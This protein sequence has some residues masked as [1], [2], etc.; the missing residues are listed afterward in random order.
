MSYTKADQLLSDP[1]D[2]YHEAWARLFNADSDDEQASTKRHKQEQPS[3]TPG[4][5]AS[6]AEPAEPIEPDLWR[7]YISHLHKSDPWWSVDEGIID[8]RCK[9]MERGNSEGIQYRGCVKRLRWVLHT[10]ES[11]FKVGMATNLGKRWELYQQGDFEDGKWCPSHIFILHDVPN[12]IAA[13]YIEAALILLC[14]FSK[15]PIINNLNFQR[16]DL[17]GTGAN[18]PELANQRHW[19]YLAVRPTVE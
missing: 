2:G 17:G 9:F 6:A 11:Q 18:K 14:S 8:L 10:R 5:A 19:I 16:N 3:G 1:D 13:G 4:P 12:R 7:N 15:Q